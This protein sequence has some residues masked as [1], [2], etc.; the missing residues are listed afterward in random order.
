[1]H[2]ASAFYA[3]SR[4][5][6]LV[7]VVLQ[8]CFESGSMSM[9]LM[10]LSSHSSCTPFSDIHAY[11]HPAIPALLLDRTFLAHLHALLIVFDLLSFS[12]LILRSG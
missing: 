11:I 9:I 10:F 6:L 3:T 4:V 2:K 5:S 1:M 7:W 12:F 8:L